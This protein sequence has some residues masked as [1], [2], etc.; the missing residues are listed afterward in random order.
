MWEITVEETQSTTSQLVRYEAARSAL[1]EASRVDE[2]KDI[3][4]KAIAMQVYA[5][6]AKDRELIDHATE[7]RLR[8]ERRAGEL[9]KDLA[10]AGERAVRKKY[11][12][13]ACDFKAIRPQ[14][15][16][17]AVQPVAKAR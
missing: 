7:I 17:A 11:E 13:A 16:Q 2:V 12:V 3:H 10:Q 6:Q 8:A 14:H 9:L 1:A 15:Q 5:R 4:D